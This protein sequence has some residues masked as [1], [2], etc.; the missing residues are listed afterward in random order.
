MPN[1]EV[2]NFK[3]FKFLQ[4]G[5]I[6]CVTCAAVWCEHIEILT[7]N[8]ADQEAIWRED[9]MTHGQVNLE[10]P[11]FPSENIWTSVILTPY[12]TKFPRYVVEWETDPNSPGSTVFICY[13][14]PG[15]G[16]SVI[17]SVLWDR[18]WGNKRRRKECV[19]PHHSYLAQVLWT[20]DMKLLDTI[21]RKAAQI[22]SVYYTGQCLH[23]ALNDGL[24]DDL[25]PDREG[26][27][28]K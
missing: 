22:W 9:G 18:M 23:C 5:H 19:M 11:M 4:D 1:A 8:G 26:N 12:G 7:A 16:R 14:N 13:L 15:E 2:W 3:G 25:V 21:P 10:I 17:R 6:Q 24:G 28:W 27:V 20:R